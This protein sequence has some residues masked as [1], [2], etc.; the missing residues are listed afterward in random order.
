[1]PLARY[2]SLR[3][4]GPVDALALPG[5][6]GAL[7]ELLSWA[8]RRQVPVLPLG[9]GFNLLV[10]DA[11][12]R[13]IAI[14]AQSLRALELEPDG[15][16]EA[17]AGVRHSSV[18]KL[19]AERGR[20]GLEFAVGIPG[21][22]GGWIAMN[23]GTREREMKDVVVSVALWTPKGEVQELAAASLHFEYRRTHIPAGSFILGARF[24]TH[25]DAPSRV[26]ARM[27]SL[28]EARRRTQPVDR[29]SCGSV[30]HNPP[31]D[32]AGRLIEA[33]GLKGERRGGAE[34]SSVH[35]NFIENRGQ[36]RARDVLELIELMRDTVR[37]RFAVELEPEVRIVGEEE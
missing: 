26:E 8:Q 1:M 36:A 31:G 7:V 24:H 32:A 23:A 25:S 37:R 16:L 30:F 2:T 28:M 10:R 22:V 14:H 20:A 21:T 27:Q 9:S 17:E 19:C 6:T 3:V 18:S 33:A 34:I 15:S 29:L 11:G 5:S 35:A 13:G 4:G 12:L